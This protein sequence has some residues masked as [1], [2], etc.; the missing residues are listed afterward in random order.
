M[1]NSKGRVKVS[2]SVEVGGGVGRGEVHRL[3]EN[4]GLTNR[5]WTLNT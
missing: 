4:K 5:F 2:D 3:N 1:E